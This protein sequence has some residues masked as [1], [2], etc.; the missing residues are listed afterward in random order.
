M[1]S[2]F[3]EKLAAGVTQIGIH[4]RRGDFLKYDELKTGRSI[5]KTPYYRKAMSYM[6]ERY[7]DC[8]F[9][10]TG[11]AEVKEWALRELGEHGELL[12]VEGQTPAEDLFLLSTMDHPDA[13][14][15]YTCRPTIIICY[16]TERVKLDD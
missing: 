2:S 5:A 10:I 14:F 7:P 11:N 13:T 4:A 16:S 12:F 6:K 1:M 3:G 9:F 8:V 15:F